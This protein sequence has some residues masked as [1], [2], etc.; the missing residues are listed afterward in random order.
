MSS[1]C[2]YVCMYVG[3]TQKSVFLS[4]NCSEALQGI[5]QSLTDN[6]SIYDHALSADDT[7]GSLHWLHSMSL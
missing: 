7:S 6:L 3:K 1:M 2:M 5:N 4:W